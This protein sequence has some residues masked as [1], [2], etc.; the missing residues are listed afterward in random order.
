MALL[1]ETCDLVIVV[2]GDGSLRLH[3]ARTLVRHRTPA[4]ALT[5]DD[6]VF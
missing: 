1:G 3:A 4:V 5:A 2:G 6:L